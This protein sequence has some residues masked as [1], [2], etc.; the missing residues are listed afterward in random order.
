MRKPNTILALSTLGN[1]SSVALAHKESC[2]Q[3][4]SDNEKHV[5]ILT[6][7]LEEVQKKSG[8]T[9]RDMDVIVCDVGPASLTGVRVGLSTVQGL[10]LPYNTPVWPRVH[11]EILAWQ[12]CQYLKVHQEKQPAVG[13]QI[14]VADDARMQA[15]SWAVFQLDR[16]NT[17]I[18]HQKPMLITPEALQTQLHNAQK[19]PLLLGN[20]WAVYQKELGEVLTK[21]QRIEERQELSLAGAMVDLALATSKQAELITQNAQDLQAFYLRPPV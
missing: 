4:T 15:I 21:G 7:L 14:W 13:Q 10:A 8:C 6:G 20:A 16:K 5:N 9:W 3:A 19:Q 11:H 1:K 2:W 17:L 12:Y 18:T